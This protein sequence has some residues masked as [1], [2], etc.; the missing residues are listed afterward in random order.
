MAYTYMLLCSDGSFYVGSTRDLEHR[1]YEHQIGEGAAYTRHRLPVQLV[2]HE[3]H[4]NVGA[5]FHREKQ[6]Q[7]WSRV[8]RLALIR[9][10]Y[11]GLPAL[12]KKDFSRRRDRS[13]ESG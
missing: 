9:Q 4:E 10:D 3:E 7:N 13:D 6:V 1:L 5:A 11:A 2:W 8:K 12:A